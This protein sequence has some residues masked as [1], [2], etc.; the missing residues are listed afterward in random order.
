MARK[1]GGEIIF[2]PSITNNKDIADL[3]RIFTDHAAKC[4]EPGYRATRENPEQ[5]E[6]I[7]VYTDGSCQN[8]R[9][10][11][12]KTGSGIWYGQNDPRN[13]ALQIVN[14]TGSNQI[15]ELTVV[16]YATKVAPL[17]APLK[18]ISDLRYAIDGITVN[19]RAWE[20]K[21]YIG[22][23]NKDLFRVIIRSLCKRGA[24]TS[25]EWI[26]KTQQE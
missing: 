9:G 24:P 16:L 14:G 4:H 20:D 12:A 22:V 5:E 11:N 15:G 2:N 3:F 17:F 21:G 8:N 13:T 18:I 23:G 10:E 6:K 19:S 1:E 7:T 26:K 25:F